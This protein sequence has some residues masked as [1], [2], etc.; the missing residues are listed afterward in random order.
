MNE[1]C[2]STTNSIENKFPEAQFPLG[3]KD[4]HG[5]AKQSE[6]ERAQS[7]NIPRES[8]F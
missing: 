4:D 8:T 3:R 7:I 2:Y 1:K 6:A 5:L